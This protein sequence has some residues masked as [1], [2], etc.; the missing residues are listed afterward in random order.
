MKTIATFVKQNVNLWGKHCPFL[1]EVQFKEG[2]VLRLSSGREA[3]FKPASGPTVNPCLVV[4]RE[5][6]GATD[7]VATPDGTII[8][9]EIR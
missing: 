2:V 7:W 1:T 6:P 5:S 3:A 4:R 8:E 9:A